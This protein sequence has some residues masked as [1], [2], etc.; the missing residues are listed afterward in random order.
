MPV[1]MQWINKIR[2]KLKK[3]AEQEYYHL[4]SDN[5]AYKYRCIQRI[6]TLELILKKKLELAEKETL[7]MVDK[8]RLEILSSAEE[9]IT[10]LS[11]C[12]EILP[13][14]GNDI[15]TGWNSKVLEQDQQLEQLEQSSQQ[16]QRY[17]PDHPDTRPDSRGYRPGDLGYD[18][19]AKF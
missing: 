11:G 6:N 5:F 19:Q 14:I 18:S 8:I 4:L 3:E 7:T 9:S 13:V 1:S 10:L 17:N 16:Q 2:N 15:T 12:D